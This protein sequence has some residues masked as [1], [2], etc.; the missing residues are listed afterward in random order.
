MR[1]PLIELFVVKFSKDVIDLF[2]SGNPVHTSWLHF[3]RAMTLFL[4][5]WQSTAVVFKKPMND[6]IEFCHIEEGGAKIGLGD[7]SDF[8]VKAGDG[9]VMNNGLQPVWHVDGIVKKS[10]VITKSASPA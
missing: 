9:F 6:Q 3:P 5:Q 1:Q 10:I 2:V 4:D 7:G 8:R